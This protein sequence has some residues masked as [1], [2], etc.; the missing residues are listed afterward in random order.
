MSHVNA[1]DQ[2]L[3]LGLTCRYKRIPMHTTTWR[4]RETIQAPGTRILMRNEATTR[5]ATISLVSG[6]ASEPKTKKAPRT[7]TQ[8]VGRM[9]SIREVLQ[10]VVYNSRRREGIVKIDERTYLLNG[11]CLS[12]TCFE[13]E[14][15]AA[16]CLVPSC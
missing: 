13:E 11:S 2:S 8:A 16:N 15:N 1:G 14:A 9:N 10:G 6:G 4:R 3:T 12:E 7:I 5:K